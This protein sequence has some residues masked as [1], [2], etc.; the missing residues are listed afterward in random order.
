[1][2]S[3]LLKI[4]VSVLLICSTVFAFGQAKRPGEDGYFPTKLEWAALELQALH[5]RNV[6]THESSLMVTFVAQPDGV[7]VLCYLQYT[8]DFQAAALKIERDALEKA[9]N[10]YRQSHKWGWLRLRFQERAIS[11]PWPK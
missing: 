4:A 2:Y 8:I 6:M 1:M 7:T 11:E 9:F 3:S 5:G 10:L